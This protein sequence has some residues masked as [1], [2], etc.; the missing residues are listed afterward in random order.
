MTFVYIIFD[1]LIVFI[2]ICRE[3]NLLS[4]NNLQNQVLALIHE[5]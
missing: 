1:I 2:Y 5:Y 4:E 3:F